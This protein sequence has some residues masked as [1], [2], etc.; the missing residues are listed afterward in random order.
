MYLMVFSFVSLQITAIGYNNCKVQPWLRQIRNPTKKHLLDV[1]KAWVETYFSSNAAARKQ[2]ERVQINKV[3]NLLL[4]I[5][6]V[7]ATA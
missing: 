3:Q 1:A 6:A 4:Y 5:Q 7:T 2:E